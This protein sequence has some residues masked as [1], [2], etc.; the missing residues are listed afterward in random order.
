MTA[1]LGDIGAIFGIALA[2]GIGYALLVHAVYTTDQEHP[3][4]FAWVVGGVSLTLIIGLLF[5]PWEVIASLAGLFVLTGTP[6]VLGAM[7]RERLRRRQV[8][9]QVEATLRAGN[10]R[11][12]G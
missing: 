6:Q 8:E 4:T 3:F 10:A 5:L 2:T 1:H 12:E 11:K 9:R 7:Y